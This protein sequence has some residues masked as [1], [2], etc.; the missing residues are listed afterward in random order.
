MNSSCRRRAS[1]YRARRLHAYEQRPEEHGHEE[2]RARDGFQHG[3]SDSIRS[4]LAKLWAATTQS[5]PMRSACNRKLPVPSCASSDGFDGDH[6]VA[7]RAGAPVVSAVECPTC[8]NPPKK[9]RCIVHVV[10]VVVVANRAGGCWLPDGLGQP[11]LQPGIDLADEVVPFDKVEAD[12]D[13]HVRGPDDHCRRGCDSDRVGRHTV[14][15]TAQEPSRRHQTV[16][17]CPDRFD[18][19]AA[20]GD[21]GPQSGQVDIKGIGASASVSSFHTTRDRSAGHD[22]G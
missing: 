11:L 14:C 8:L 3:G 13:A 17:K 20:G 18:L 22:G 7:G 21:L 6:A 16:A 9:D 2:Y 4:A 5:S 1:L 12:D 19:G 10:R 15:A